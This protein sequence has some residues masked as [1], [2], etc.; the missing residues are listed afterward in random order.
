LL[1]K[2]TNLDSAIEKQAII[3]ICKRIQQLHGSAAIQFIDL[4]SSFN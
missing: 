1:W 4:K 3:R 2:S